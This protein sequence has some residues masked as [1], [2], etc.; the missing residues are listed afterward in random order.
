VVASVP[1]SLG[2]VLAKGRHAAKRGP[3][4]EDGGENDGD[5]GE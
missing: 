5:E 3:K 2:V 4:D 1:P